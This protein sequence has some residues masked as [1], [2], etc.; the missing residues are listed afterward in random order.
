[1]SIQPFS[2]FIW[3]TFQR[4]G[5]HR[6]PGAPEEVKY[7]NLKHRH[8]FKFKVKIEVHH[9]DREI[10]FHMFL[11]KIESWYD[12]G[13]L[14]LDYKSCEMMA[15]DLAEKI[16]AEYGDPSTGDITDKRQ[17]M[18]EVS[19]DGECGAECYYSI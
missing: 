17:L 4:K 16:S 15:T 7:L 1:M 6:Y 11:N 13:S 2:Q 8:L 10:E 5:F 3:V 12:N 9:D 18:I 14:E 19:E